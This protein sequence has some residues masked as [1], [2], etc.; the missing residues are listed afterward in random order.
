MNVP[1]LDFSE[2][3]NVIKDKVDSGLKKVFEKGCFILGPDVKEFEND[4]LKKGAVPINTDEPL[5]KVV[6]NI[7]QEI[8]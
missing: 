7:M 6:E 2:Q 5:E 1:F 8:Q 3:Y 4:L